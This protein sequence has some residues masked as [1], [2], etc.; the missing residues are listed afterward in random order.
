MKQTMIRGVLV[1]AAFA[2]A[3]PVFAQTAEVTSVKPGIDTV[4]VQAAVDVREQAIAGVWSTYS[5]AMTSALSARQAALHA[6][7]GTTDAPARRLARNTAWQTFRTA[8]T[9]AHASLRTARQAAW[10][11]FST[12]SKACGVPV[13]EARGSDSVGGIGL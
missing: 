7:W 6:A 1:T 12:A 4:C 2:L 10:S 5:T 11:A 9:A 8:Q 3:A 13:V